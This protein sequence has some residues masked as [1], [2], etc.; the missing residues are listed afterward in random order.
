MAPSNLDDV[1][2][3]AVSVLTGSDHRSRER[4]ECA[5]NEAASTEDLP[6]GRRPDGDEGGQVVA[7]GP[8]SLST[9]VIAHWDEQAIFPDS[10]HGDAA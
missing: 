2:A 4:R 6:L 10:G 8:C 9:G 5:S 7:R 1:Q 3:V